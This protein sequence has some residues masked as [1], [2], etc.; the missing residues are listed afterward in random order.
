MENPEIIREVI[1]PLLIPLLYIL[2]IGTFVSMN[3]CPHKTIRLIANCG[4]FSDLATQIVT[5][6]YCLGKAIVYICIIAISASIGCGF[7][8]GMIIIS[9]IIISIYASAFFAKATNDT[10]GG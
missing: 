2:A 10:F 6:F 3:I 8:I 1:I 9:K 5:A 4:K 7:I